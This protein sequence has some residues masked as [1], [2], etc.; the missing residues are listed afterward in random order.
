MGQN[1]TDIEQNLEILLSLGL[2]ENQHY[3][4]R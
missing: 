2:E 3:Q 1:T 4:E